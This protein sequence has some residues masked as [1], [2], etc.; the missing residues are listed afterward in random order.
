MQQEVRT[1]SVVPAEET[2][3]RRGTFT[4]NSSEDTSTAVLSL[5]SDHHHH[6]HQIEPRN[7]EPNPLSKQ[8]E[9]DHQI[10]S[11]VSSPTDRPTDS[12][13]L[14]LTQNHTIIIVAVLSVF[15][16]RYSFLGLESIYRSLCLLRPLYTRRVMDTESHP[17][18]YL[19]LP[20]RSSFPPESRHGLCQQQRGPRLVT[21]TSPVY[22]ASIWPP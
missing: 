10:Q 7:R 15:P 14:S 8:T 17:P 9:T 3:N 18:L 20:R 13:C 16:S 4:V 5:S 6:I 1:A 12:L 11:Q 21:H 2:N 22:S 19:P